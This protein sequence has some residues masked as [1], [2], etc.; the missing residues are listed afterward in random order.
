MASFVE[1]IAL[2]L[3]GGFL[4]FVATRVKWSVEREKLLLEERRS[5]LRAWRGFIHAEFEQLSFCDT[6]VYSEMRPF[7]SKQTRSAIE[8]G[9]IAIRLGR[10]GNVIKSL[11]LDD[12]SSLEK[13]WRLI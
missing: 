11:I 1:K 7:L 3:V 8:G 13:A 9:A 10:G 5:K 4:G 6:T 2:L 12:L